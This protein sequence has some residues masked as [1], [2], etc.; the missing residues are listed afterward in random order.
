MVELVLCCGYSIIR[1]KV[2][3]SN[4]KPNL[5][6]YKQHLPVMPK[7]I[8]QVHRQIVNPRVMAARVVYSRVILFVP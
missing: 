5:A 6:L 2:G 7:L 8:V 1:S 3:I 4:G